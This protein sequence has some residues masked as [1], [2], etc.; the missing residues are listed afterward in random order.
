MMLAWF[1]KTPLKWLCINGWWCPLHIFHVWAFLQIKWVYFVPVFRPAISL[2]NPPKIFLFH[3][4]W[5]N[6]PWRTNDMNFIRPTVVIDW[7]LFPENLARASRYVPVSAEWHI[8]L[9]GSCAHSL[10]IN[11][12][13]VVYSPFLDG[14]PLGCLSWIQCIFWQ[15]FRCQQDTMLSMCDSASKL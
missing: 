4:R 9:W 13:E 11:Y 8:Y 12:T 6:W 15:L 3:P 2:S 7:K 1:S 14:F 5:W 10:Q